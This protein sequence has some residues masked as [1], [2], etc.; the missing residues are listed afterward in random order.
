MSIILKLLITNYELRIKNQEIPVRISS[1][2]PARDLARKL[3]RPIVA[4]SANISGKGAIYD[5][6][7]IVEEFKDENKRFVSK[8]NNHLNEARK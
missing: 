4:T 2:K 3:G 5:S 7:E 6:R 1:C 8:S